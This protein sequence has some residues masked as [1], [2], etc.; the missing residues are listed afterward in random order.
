MNTRRQFVLNTIY[1]GL[2]VSILPEIKCAPASGKAEHVIY[3]NMAGGMS[4]IDSFD[5]KTDK[6]IA[7]EYTGIKTKVDSI[8][9]NSNL[10]GLANHT[11][12]MAL[13]RGMSVTTGDHAGGQYIA[14][15]SYKKLGTI[16]HPAM[17]A[18]MTYFK[19]DKQPHSIPQ[20]ILIG[21]S[22]DHPGSGWMYKKY[23]PVPIQDPLR[24]LDNTVVKNVAELNQRIDILNA[25]NRDASKINNPGVKGYA[26][27]YNQT[28]KLLESKDLEVFDISKEKKESRDKYGSTKFGQG[29]CL[30]KRLIEK[31]G[32]K[33]IEVT[34]GGWDNHVEVFNA[35]DSNLLDVDTALTALINELTALDLM[36]KTL[37]VIATEFGRTPTI[38]VNNGRDHFPRAY[39][40]VLIGAG[41]KGGTIYG[42]TD[43][44]G[45]NVIDQQCSVQDFNATI[46]AAIG[47][48][49]E[50][51]VISPEGRPFTIADKGKPIVQVLS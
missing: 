25:L 26:E 14:H 51:K 41:I 11:D 23:S 13:I 35:M 37:I 43:A 46:A 15:T 4:H 38:N 1:T 10:K 50:Q 16:V 48:P 9:I 30:A 47:L 32:V 18:W 39:S 20:N 8:E 40:N 19:D 7:G 29:L 45:S 33:F 5:P 36:K 21:G 28:F 44:Q 6:A 2:G 34:R 22:A 31:A 24:G 27:F 17:G 49:I 3:I 12:K 42:K